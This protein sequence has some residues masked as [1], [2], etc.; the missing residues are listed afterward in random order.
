M[1][2]SVLT[3][4]DQH[5]GPWPCCPCLCLPS[6]AMGTQSSS[7]LVPVQL[8][9]PGAGNDPDQHPDPAPASCPGQSHELCART[10]VLG[11]LLR[12]AGTVL[13]T[14]SLLRDRVTSRMWRDS[15]DATQS[16]CCAPECSTA[17]PTPTA[18]LHPLPPALLRFHIDPHLNPL[19]DKPTQN[20]VRHVES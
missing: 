13:V 3:P 6:P 1:F 10:G 5:T 9:Q 14:D 2:P 17:H 18:A 15:H 12:A 8:L 4:P 7:A 16:P 19:M 20:P 11:L